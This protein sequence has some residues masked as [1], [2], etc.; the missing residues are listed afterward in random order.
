[1]VAGFRGAR[2]WRRR[3]VRDLRDGGAV[4]LIDGGPDAFGDRGKVVPVELVELDGVLAQDATRLVAGHVLEAL[5]DPLAGVGERPLRVGEVVAPQQ[6]A[7]A[8]VVP[9]SDV[10]HPG[11]GRRQEAVAV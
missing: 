9:A 8:H 6:V 1:M 2:T 3:P 7:D 4:D 10:L 5:P 11:R